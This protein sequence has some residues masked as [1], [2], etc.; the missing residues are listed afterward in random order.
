MYIYIIYSNAPRIPPG[1]FFTA[2]C[3]SIAVA[4]VEVI[5]AGGIW[6]SISSTLDFVWVGCELGGGGERCGGRIS[7]TRDRDGELLVLLMFVLYF[8]FV[9]RYE[10]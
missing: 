3:V 1:H 7:G 6:G 9:L 4:V 2:L 5:F 10:G 8:F